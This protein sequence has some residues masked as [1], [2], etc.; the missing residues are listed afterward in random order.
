MPVI[1]YPLGVDVVG[2]CLADSDGFLISPPYGGAE[3]S[4]S[5]SAFGVPPKVHHEGLVKDVPVLQPTAGTT[6]PITA[7]ANNALVAVLGPRPGAP[8]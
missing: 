1:T 3:A 2:Y 7:A 5:A 4:A 6:H 8:P